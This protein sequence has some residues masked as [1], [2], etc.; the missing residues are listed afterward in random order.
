M[1]LLGNP[2]RVLQLPQS[3]AEFLKEADRESRPIRICGQFPIRSNQCDR[4]ARV[5]CYGKVRQESGLS[6]LDM[7]P[8]LRRLEF[9]PVSDHPVPK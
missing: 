4:T 9:K 7:G 1:D 6:E 2:G 3:A 5:R 8:L